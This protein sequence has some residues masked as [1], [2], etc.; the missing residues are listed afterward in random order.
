MVSF[1]R[2]FNYSLLLL[3]T[4]EGE[5]RDCWRLSV[6]PGNQNPRTDAE[7]SPQPGAALPV[8]SGGCG[9]A[10]RTLLWVPGREGSSH[11]PLT[12]P[13]HPIHLPS[14]GTRGA[15]TRPCEAQLP[16]ARTHPRSLRAPAP[17]PA[18]TGLC[19]PAAARRHRCPRRCWTTLWPCRGRGA[20]EAS[21]RAGCRSPAA[22]RRCSSTP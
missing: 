12:E 22:A 7:P 11:R 13:T 15:H 6:N 16:H 9:R 5:Q 19:R 21:S 17:R 20:A 4:T 2:L 8:S 18:E 14:S 1:C 10:Q 3:M